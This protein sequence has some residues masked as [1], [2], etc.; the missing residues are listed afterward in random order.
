MTKS[1]V[2][3]LVLSL[4]ACKA[5]VTTGSDSKSHFSTWAATPPMGWNS[6]D[7]F[8]AAVYESDVKANADYM[9]ANLID[10]GWEYIVVDYCWS[11]PHP[12]GNGQDNPP[13]YELP[14]GGLV[15]WLAMDNYG[16]LLPDVS[17]FPSCNADAGFKPLADYVHSLGLKFGIHIMRGVPRQAVLHK[18]P[19][20]GAEG[21]DCSMIA[22][23][24]SVCNWLNQMW[25]IDMSKPGAQEYLNSLI[26]LYASWD[27]DFI[28]I[29]DMDGMRN[30]DDSYHRAEVEGYRKAIDQCGRPI[31][32]SLSPR[33]TYSQ[34][35]GHANQHAN[36]WRISGDFWDDWDK[37][38]AMFP[39]LEQW[40][41]ERLPGCYPDAD[42]IPFG[43]LRRRGPFGTESNSRF[44]PDEHVT[45][46]SFWCITKSPLMFGC[47]LPLTDDFTLALITNKEVIAVNQ[48][49]SNPKPL[50]S[51]SDRAI[52]T[53]DAMDGSKYVGLFNLSDSTIVL[54]VSKE[55]LGLDA[56]FEVLD[57]WK[58]NTTGTFETYSASVNAH[59]ALLLQLK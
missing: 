17:K 26:A 5:K 33:I 9:A 31:V 55:L 32:Y 16:R 56:P 47:D 7:C 8:G 18:L 27:V 3:L 21:I 36:M 19:V 34:A 52:W 53:S 22:D 45:L 58:K 30:R 40:N 46:M 4:V 11:Y 2:I 43:R 12:P 57:L 35:K 1:V 44:T 54:E 6:Y 50:L 29:D 38:K 41:D 42:M 15:P 13:Q 37:L 59:G 23:T 14:R 48:T 49:G 39:L 10:A 24:S 20:L 51:A 25:G 28:K